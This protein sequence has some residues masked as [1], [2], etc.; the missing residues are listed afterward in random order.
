MCG[1]TTRENSN[2]ELHHCLCELASAIVNVAPKNAFA[3]REV[4]I[5]I[6]NRSMSL[7]CLNGALIANFLLNI[8]VLLH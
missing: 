4:V 6:T 2:T 5:D 7:M 3:M 8:Y 1:R